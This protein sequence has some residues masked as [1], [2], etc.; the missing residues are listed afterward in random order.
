VAVARIIRTC[1]AV[2]LAL[3]VA[4]P[5]EASN[6]PLA[7]YARA[8]L[9]DS[10][11]ESKA[12]VEAY[13]AALATASDED[14]I[15][16]RAYREAIASGDQTLALRAARIRNARR[17]ST[18]DAQLLIFG[19]SVKR[20]DWPG[21]RA[22]ISWIEA[23]GSLAFLTPVL[24]AWTD[25]GARSGD[26]MAALS[27]A[28]RPD[29]LASTYIRGHRVL[30]QLAAGRK[31]DGLAE[32]RAHIDG[33]SRTLPL[34]L[35]AAAQ[36]VAL[37]DRESALAVLSGD[38]PALMKARTLVTAGKPLPGA[39]NTASKGTAWL[40]ATVSRDLMRDSPSGAAVTLAR[41]AEFGDPA[42]DAVRLTLAQALSLSDDD[43]AALAALDR[44]DPAGIYGESA[45]DTRIAVLQRA[46]RN[47]DAA[48][49]S[50]QNARSGKARDLA[51]L[52]DALARISQF[53]EAAEAYGQAITKLE[54][55][56]VQVSWTLW[57]LR[58]GA[59]ESAK[60]WSAAKPALEKALA[61]GGDQPEVLNH[62]GFAMLERGES[63]ERATSLIARAQALRP[64]DA[65]I[66]D[67]LGWAWYKRGEFG[68]AIPILEAAASRDPTI[69]EISEHLGDAYWAA[70][71]RIDARYSWHAA[72]VQAEDDGVRQRLRG[73]IADGPEARRP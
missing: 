45:A 20:A 6:S 25:F 15:V 24:T 69:A 29:G 35:A 41:L 70:G 56:K 63:M 39:V 28:E 11:G 2:L 26:P 46:G 62:L 43:G 7:S 36:L 31:A 23:D 68:K 66:N 10:A 37:K 55:D 54:A 19:D 42:S 40:F 60:D 59:L 50:R 34:R 47:A 64:D 53:R 16:L 9:A 18:P 1:S 57:F 72:L 17:L 48:L 30:M 58:G 65:A 13:A 14:S 44:I 4:I 51:Q 21:A 12:A 73:K 52:G 38:D 32:L 33:N 67:S 61:L 8:R 27:R 3:A 49:L 22:A 71:R 5:A